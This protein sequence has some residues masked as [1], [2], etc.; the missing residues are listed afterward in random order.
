MRYRKGLELRCFE[1]A[2]RLA[3][4]GGSVSNHDGSHM[5]NDV[6]ALLR[7]EG[8]FDRLG[9]TRSQRI[10]SEMVSRAYEEHDCRHAEILEGHGAA[11]GLCWDCMEPSGDIR[12][13]LCPKCRTERGYTEEDVR[14]GERNMRRSLWLTPENPLDEPDRL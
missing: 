10:V 14:M 1:Y 9:R 5:L 8:V 6:I 12:A 2:T 3:I 13:D 7:R 4:Q 11:L